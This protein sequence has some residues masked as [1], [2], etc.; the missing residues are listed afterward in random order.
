MNPVDDVPHALRVEHG[1]VTDLLHRWVAGE[2]AAL[3]QLLPVIY[4]ELRSV[5]RSL[6][7]RESADNTLQATGL[8]HE[9]FIRLSRR[10][11]AHWRTRGE[12]FAWAAKVMRHVLIDHA[13]A[14]RRAKRGGGVAH[15]CV[16]EYADGLPASCGDRDWLE[17]MALDEALKRLERL[18]VQ[19]AQIVELRFFG[20]LGVEETAEAL[21]ISAATV[22]RDWATARIWL[23]RELRGR[24]TAN[25]VT[26]CIS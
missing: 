14:R 11:T 21:G 7:R 18:D 8:V 24:R 9:T 1:V 6:V 3:D 10:Q 13:R 16:D 15:V 4:E 22:K 23:L 2:S 26:T 12:F 17:L 5:A 20:D 19:Q 25:A